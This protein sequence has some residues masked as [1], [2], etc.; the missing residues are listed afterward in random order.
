MALERLTV[1]VA[2]STRHESMAGRDYLVV[3]MVMITEGVHAGSQ[4]PLYY[5]SA[6]L[7]R[8]VNL[9]DHKPIVIYHPEQNGIGI[10]A[11]DPDV[12]TNQGVGLIMNTKFKGGKLRAEAWLE[13]T[14]LNAVDSRV[15]N[16]LE[17]DAM[18]E[19]ST[20]LFT[21]NGSEP[22][23][24]NGKEYAQTARNYRPDHLAI[25]PDKQGACSIKDGAGL[26]R[27]HAPLTPA[28]TTNDR[29]TSGL[30]TNEMS[31]DDIRC[32]LGSL[33]DQY[34]WICDVYDKYMIY[35][36][37]ANKLYRQDYNVDSKGVAALV[38]NPSEVIRFSEYRTADGKPVTNQKGNEMDR[39]TQI[40]GLITANSGWIEADRPWLTEMP[41]DK[42]DK[43]AAAKAPV[44]NAQPTGGLV[45]NGSPGVPPVLTPAQFVQAVLNPGQPLTPT[46]LPA[47]VLPTTNAAPAQPA[48]MTQEQATQAYIMNAP[49]G[50]VRDMLNSMLLTTNAKKTALIQEITA[51]A[52][53]KFAPAFLMDQTPEF[54]EGLAQLARPVANQQPQPQAAPVAN[55]AGAAGGMFLPPTTNA[56]P[57]GQA[58]AVEALP[59]PSMSFDTK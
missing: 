24:W 23:E 44:G 25:L 31:F 21:D 15:T 17:S 29:R 28:K 54:L 52:Q 2:G 38:G 18:V 34:S 8:N 50:P 43:L 27:N 1:N 5:P 13:K 57:G 55:Y 20:G 40:D 49:A 48:V 33:L 30:T 4:G 26:N 53:N 32:A 12:L 41:Q 22:G 11:C 42:F 59:I 39:K 35:S 7:S 16:S 47:P 19:L 6:E 45:N 3:P 14:R 56:T 10:S 46:P 9:W 51:N 37:K 36:D 58:T